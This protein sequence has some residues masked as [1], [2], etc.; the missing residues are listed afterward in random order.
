[1]STHVEDDRAV[2]RSVEQESPTSPLWRATQAHAAQQS[3]SRRPGGH[4][5]AAAWGLAAGWWTP[6]GR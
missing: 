5:L 4:L 6:A 1:M 2:T 3:S